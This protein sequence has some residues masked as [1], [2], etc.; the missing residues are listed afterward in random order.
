MTTLF[1]NNI[2]G[3]GTYADPDDDTKAA[4]VATDMQIALATVSNFAYN[5]LTTA[6]VRTTDAG[7]GRTLNAQIDGVTYTGKECLSNTEVTTMGTAVKDAILAR[8]GVT[9]VGAIS[10]DLWLFNAPGRVV[11]ATRIQNRVV[12]SASPSNTNVLAWSSGNSQWEPTA[13]GGGLTEGDILDL[14]YAMNS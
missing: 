4:A 1:I 14:A 3:T 12:A 9:S 13:A 5:N 7:G 6:W 11:N 8:S 2:V 10:I